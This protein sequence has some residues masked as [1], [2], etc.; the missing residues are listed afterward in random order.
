MKLRESTHCYIDFLHLEGEIDMHY[1]PVLRTLLQAKAKRRC[2]ALAV[3]L[4]GVSFIDSTGIAVLIE[5]LRDAAEFDGKFCLARPTEQ[6]GVIFEIVQLRKALPIFATIPE[7]IEALRT[8]SRD[9]IA[10]PTF[11][12][13]A[14]GTRAVAA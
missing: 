7:A 1:A 10:E 2:P 4:E 3:D 8:R 9:D 12:G 11:S 6:V 5:Y 14:E 13:A